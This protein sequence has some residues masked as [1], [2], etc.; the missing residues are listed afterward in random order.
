MLYSEFIELT[1]F[2]FISSEIYHE[3]IEQAYCNYVGNKQEFCDILTNLSDYPVLIDGF[4]SSLIWGYEG[5]GYT[6]PFYIVSGYANDM[7]IERTTHFYTKCAALIA[8]RLVEPLYPDF[9][10]TIK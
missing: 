1:G 8:K 5:I 9:I 6:S 4:I 2:E 7:T 3:E 10:F